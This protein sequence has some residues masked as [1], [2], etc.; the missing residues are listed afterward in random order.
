MKPILP[1]KRV[2]QNFASNLRMER[3]HYFSHIQVKLLAFFP[4]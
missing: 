4:L 3:F 1:A 2:T